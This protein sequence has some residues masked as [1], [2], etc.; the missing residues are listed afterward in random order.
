MNSYQRIMETLRHGKPDRV[1]VSPFTLG[2]LDYASSAAQDLI[3]ETDPF[4]R[5]VGGGDPFIGSN[6]QCSVNQE[7]DTTISTLFTPKGELTTRWRRTPETEGSVEYGIKTLDDAERFLSIPYSP[8]RIDTTQYAK[9]RGRIQGEGLVM[10]EVTDAICLPAQWL[11]PEDFCTWTLDYPDLV[12]DM[13]RIGSRRVNQYVDDLCRAGV[14]AFRI[15]G[16]EYAVT[17]LGPS[18]FD[19]LVAP[20]DTELIDIIHSH[21]ALAYYHCHGCVNGYLDKLANLGMD[22]LDPLEAPPWGNVEIGEA[23]KRIGDR[24]CLVGNL[25]DMEVIDSLPT[26]AVVDLAE[27][28]LI[29]AGESGFILGGT[30][31]GT[32]TEYGAHNFVEIARMVKARAAA[33]SMLVK[34]HAVL[35]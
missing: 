27:D 11:S 23:V 31:S 34:E 16:G 26:Q 1:P 18:G 20:F 14:N 21:G 10:V 24:V 3:R 7:G 25:D 19:K 4:I 32:F 6:V 2:A 29:S 28:R 9:W 33:R 35:T 5:T 17:Q 8:V 13:V 12:L 15:I 22:F 30:A